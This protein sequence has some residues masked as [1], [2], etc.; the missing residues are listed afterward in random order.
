MEKHTC[1]DEEEKRNLSR[2]LKLIEG[3]VKGIEKMIQNDAYC[4]EVLIQ[5]SAVI[6]ALNSVNKIL[7]SSHIKN[8]VVND[9]QHGSQEALDELVTV[10]HRLMK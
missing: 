7:L 4:P 9:V 3:Q 2:R 10:L 6:S 1:R 8:C 5:I